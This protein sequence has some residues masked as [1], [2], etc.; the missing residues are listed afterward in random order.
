MFTKREGMSFYYLAKGVEEIKVKQAGHFLGL[1]IL[2]NVEVQLPV[3]VALLSKLVSG[4]W[5][6]GSLEDRL[7]SLKAINLLA[8]KHLETF[9][10]DP[11]QM[12]EEVLG[13]KMMYTVFEGGQ[14]G[15]LCE[16]GQEIEVTA[17]NLKH[18]AEDVI[19]YFLDKSVE[20]EFTAFKEGFAMAANMDWLPLVEP[21]VLQLAFCGLTAIDWELLEKTTATEYHGHFWSQHPAVCN[22]NLCRKLTLFCR[23]TFLCNI[24]SPKIL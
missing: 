15:P 19:E 5:K 18:Y 9:L 11:K 3:P 14:E 8:G 1:A 16:G 23:E 17:D 4:T 22:R 12:S 20:A 6:R 13:I 21:G 10:K 7:D 2:N 24:F